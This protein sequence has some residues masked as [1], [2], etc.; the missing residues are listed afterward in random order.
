MQ[1]RG[2]IPVLLKHESGQSIVLV[3]DVLNADWLR[4][5]APAIAVLQTIGYQPRI[6]D[7]AACAQTPDSFVTPNRPTLLQIFSRGNPFRGSAGL[8]DNAMNCLR[9]LRH[10][11]CLRGVIVYGSPYVA[12]YVLA[13]LPD[14][15]PFG[16]TYGQTPEA[17]AELLA[18]L[19]PERRLRMTSQA[20]TD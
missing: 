6:S 11:N 16:F 1:V 15:V 13:A 17:Q 8:S 18:G 10:H 4:S 12:K 14:D 7:A 20:F 19:M 3:D 9:A 2:Q 5:H